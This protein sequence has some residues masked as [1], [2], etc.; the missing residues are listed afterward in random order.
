L[1]IAGTLTRESTDHM[2][3][4]FSSLTRPARWLVAFGAATAASALAHGLVWMAAGMPSLVGPVTWRKPIV[5]GLSLA[6][7]SWSLAWVLRHLPDDRGI[8]RQTAALIALLSVELL[9]IDLQQWRGVGSHFN[10]ATPLDTAIFNAM[11]LLIVLAAAILAWWTWR[12]MRRPRRDLPAEHLAAAR[13]GM[14]LLGVGNLIGIA[15]AAWG[16]TML[17]TTGQ[18]PSS[19]GAAGNP[20]LTHAL[21]LHGLQVLPMLA[22]WLGPVLGDDRRL[23]AMHRAIAGYA[24]LLGW[25]LWQAGAGRAPLDVTGPSALV[26]ATG[27]LLLAWPVATAALAHVTAA[28]PRP[29][30]A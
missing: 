1:T 23:A 13:A 14:V 7:L 25:A 21:A 17:A 20:K 29:S 5:F 12:L 28:P 11:G 30:R 2:P 15:L 18:V 16:S 8:R 3:H 19:L 9:L 26:A 10:V 27:A 6:V 24:I 22:W 4:P